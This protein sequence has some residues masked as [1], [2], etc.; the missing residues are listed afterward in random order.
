MLCQEMNPSRVT[1]LGL[2]PTPMFRILGLCS[3]GFVS[4]TNGRIYTSFTI[5]NAVAF[6]LWGCYYTDV[7]QAGFQ[8]TN[9]TIVA[10]FTSVALGPS[11]KVEKVFD[12]GIE[13][14]KLRS[15]NCILLKRDDCF[16]W[17][18]MA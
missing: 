17:D 1:L 18:T 4:T 14:D 7:Q 8:V 16:D 9:D 15:H 3:A 5:E 12:L 11:E 6:L 10:N 13:G 2:D